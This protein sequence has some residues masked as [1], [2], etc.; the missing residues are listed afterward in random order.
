[1]AVVGKSGGGLLVGICIIVTPSGSP[2]ANN[3]GLKI[4]EAIVMPPYHKTNG[5]N[6]SA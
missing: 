5:L 2:S 4:D 3:G 1:M 6:I